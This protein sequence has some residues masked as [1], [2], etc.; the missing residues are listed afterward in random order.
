MWLPNGCWRPYLHDGPL[1]D[2]FDAGLWQLLRHN[3][4]TTKFIPVTV[5]H[6]RDVTMEEDERR[7]K[8]EM[9]EYHKRA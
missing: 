9:E 1:P 4:W 2:T 3:G 5:N 8:L 7:A 6:D